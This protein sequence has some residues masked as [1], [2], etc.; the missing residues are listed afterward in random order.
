MRESEIKKLLAIAGTVAPNFPVTPATVKVWQLALDDVPLPAAEWA[1][2]EWAKTE[3]WFPTPSEVRRMI[4][5]KLTGSPSPGDAWEMVEE[6]IKRVHPDLFNRRTEWD[7]P[8]EVQRAVLQL[9]GIFR[10]WESTSIA[11]DRREFEEIYTA[12]VERR[13]REANIDQLYHQLEAEGR[14]PELAA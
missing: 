13:F 3:K 5:A 6:R 4:V 7:A 12:I 2:H 11:S 9:G 1:M 8:E 10:L 14:L